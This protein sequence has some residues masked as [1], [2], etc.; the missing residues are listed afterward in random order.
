M[1]MIG[2]S[3]KE[4]A[5]LAA[6]QLKNVARVWYEQWKNKR[7]REAGHAAWEEYKGKFLDWFFPLELRK[8]RI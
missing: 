7:E 1:A 5:H 4:K 3:S 6:Y 8:V 2:V